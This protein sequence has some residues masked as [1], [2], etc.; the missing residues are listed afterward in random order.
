MN[1]SNA[2]EIEVELLPC[3][4]PA[5][6]SGAMGDEDHTPEVVAER[7]AWHRE[8]F[9]IGTVVVRDDEVPIRITSMERPT[10]GG[11]VYAHGDQLD[12]STRKPTGSSN[13]ATG[14]LSKCKLG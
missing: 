3:G 10:V 1:T 2:V 6:A 13:W 7:I 4:R 9:S 5:R 12:R 14:P 11:Y 8:R